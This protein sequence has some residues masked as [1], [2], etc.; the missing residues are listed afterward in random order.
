[1]HSNANSSSLAS[2]S[3]Y[4]AASQLAT[5]RSGEV[6][7]KRPSSVVMADSAA[8]LNAIAHE[9]SQ[10]DTN[11][12]LETKSI[13]GRTRPSSAKTLPSSS[14]YMRRSHSSLGYSKRSDTPDHSEEQQKQPTTMTTM[15]S[16]SSAV[17]SSTGAGGTTSSARPKHLSAGN[18]SSNGDKSRRPTSARDYYHHQQ[19]SRKESGNETQTNIS[20]STLETHLERPHSV[21][22][23]SDHIDG[24]VST[25][26]RTR[27]QS[28]GGLSSAPSSGRSTP[29]HRTLSGTKIGS[30]G[31]GKDMPDG[32]VVS[33][34]SKA[35]TG[36]VSYTH[37]TL[38]TIY[39]V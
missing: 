36:P 17:S 5:R 4:Q 10:G 35:S 9:L 39:S 7:G 14:G 32:G 15:T 38:P 26:A 33:S 20:D 23:I 6:R 34:T 13:V 21:T 30:G 24:P 1:M 22:N 3:R 27:K 19:H 31:G 25:S 2:Q 37:L 28:G 12:Q 11:S 29:T 16:S 18:R 8:D